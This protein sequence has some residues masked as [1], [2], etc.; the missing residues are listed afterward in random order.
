MVPL[1]KTRP[2][3]AFVFILVVGLQPLAAQSGKGSG[4]STTGSNSTGSASR[5]PTAQPTPDAGISPT[6]VLSGNVIIADGSPL[7]EPV[8]IEQ[9]CGTRHVR[10]AYTDAKGFFSFQLGQTLPVMQ[11]ASEDARDTYS[12]GSPMLQFRSNFGSRP[13]TLGNALSAYAGCELRGLLAGFQSTSVMI[14]VTGS[15]EPTNVGTIVLVRGEKH[16]FTV[17]ATSMNV[18][19]GVRKAYERA[20]ADIQKHKLTDA[21]VALEQVVNAYPRYAAAWTDLGWVHEQQNHLDQ[22]REAFSHARAADDNFVPAYLGL[23]SVAVRQS[24][25]TEAQ[26]FS[27]RATQL[28]GADF[29]VGFYYDALA[30]FQLGQLDKAEKSARTAERLDTRHSL[31]QVQLLLG[32]ILATKQNYAQAAEEL[33][34]YL[35]VAPPAAIGEK[36]RQRLVELE[37]LSIS[38]APSPPKDLPSPAAQIPSAMLSSWEEIAQVAPNPKLPVLAS[39]QNWAPPDIDQVVPPVSLGVSCPVHDVVTGVS[40]RAKELME[41]LQQFSAV[42]RIEHM[43][44]NKNGTTRAPT[45]ATFTYVAEIHKV[46]LGQLQIAEYRDGSPSLSF[47]AQLATTGTAAHALIFHPTVIDDFTITCEGLGSL[48]G[49]LAWQLRFAQRPDRPLRFRA[50]GT[51]QGWFNAELK[52]RAWIAADTHQVMRMESDLA[53][54]IQEIRLQKDHQITDYSPV[55]FPK[56]NLRLWLPETTDIYMD[57]LGHRFHRRHSFSDFQLFWV[58]VAEKTR[59]PEVR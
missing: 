39:P 42:E 8:A 45:S 55:E 54:P 48:R 31:P 15:L 1:G 19:K 24:K 34:L 16:G 30:S 4:T 11:D 52:G 46:P 9:V 43:E 28:D 51:P 3:A 50:Y 18:P 7:P 36:V 20:I 58:D 12:Q 13:S 5:S 27:T 53:K 47:L 49:Q 21:Q 40:S 29:P 33:K 41:N 2:V 57:F 37:K 17:S 44:L 32:S 26:E 22:A 10:M 35:K 6:L 25:W 14:L 56:H 38:P 59:D 23:A